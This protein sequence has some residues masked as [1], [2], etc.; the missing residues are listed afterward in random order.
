MQLIKVT[1]TLVFIYALNKEETHT[2]D[3]KQ[4]ISLIYRAWRNYILE[5]VAELKVLGKKIANF[6]S[7]FAGYSPDGADIYS[8]TVL[9]NSFVF[10]LNELFD[11]GLSKHE[12]IIVFQK[13]E[14]HFAIV[15]Y[16]IHQYANMFGMEKNALL[17]DCRTIESQPYEIYINGYDLILVN[18]NVKYDLSESTYNNRREACEKISRLLGVDIIK[19]STKENLDHIKNK[20][21]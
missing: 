11:L 17:L 21:T 16:G 14:H 10:G 6:N 7:F 3:K 18:S 8:S 2:F 5:I 9:K 12:M 19:D 4:V 15:K 20:L 13:G 1:K